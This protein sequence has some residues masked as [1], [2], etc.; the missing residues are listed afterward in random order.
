MSSGVV[1]FVKC[2]RSEMS[3]NVCNNEEERELGDTKESI[4]VSAVLSINNVLSPDGWAG[5]GEPP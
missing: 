5:Q 1:L 4:V 2:L 3:G